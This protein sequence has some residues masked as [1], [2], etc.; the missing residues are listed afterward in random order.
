ML[1]QEHYNRLVALINSSQLLSSQEKTDWI[2]LLELMN[3]KQVKELED[4]L[5]PKAQSPMANVNQQPLRQKEEQAK[6]GLITNAPADLPV[7]DASQG[8]LQ[9]INNLPSELAAHLPQTSAGTQV[10]A[11]PSLSPSGAPLVKPARTPVTRQNI[12]QL[13]KLIAKSHQSVIN[14]SP[15]SKQIT[16]QPASQEAAQNSP[17]QT[18]RPITPQTKVDKPKSVVRAPDQKIDTN[19]NRPVI[20]IPKP[21]QVDPR[22]SLQDDVTK[23]LNQKLTSTPSD[24]GGVAAWPNKLTDA[25]VDSPSKKSSVPTPSTS[26]EVPA[27]P[28]VDLPELSSLE[29]VLQLEPKHLSL[30]NYQKIK[31]NLSDLININGYFAILHS[32][33]ASALY[34][35][36]MEYGRLSLSG[37]DISQSGFN[38]EQF[39]MMAD[40]LQEIKINRS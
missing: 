2:A 38:E 12:N 9:H 13:N 4:I 34:K 18:T 28:D 8:G 22:F 39:A 24:E 3:D 20:K 16:K 6:S 14:S 25:R 21:T 35:G 26:M 30:G 32:L 11:S 1:N 33:E 29:E 31:S 19:K 40:L 10:P 15:S 5:I 27:S 17:V 36:Y 37:R 7:P 23:I